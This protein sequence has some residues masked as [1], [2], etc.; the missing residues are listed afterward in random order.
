MITITP[1]PAATAS[2]T[3]QTLAIRIVQPVCRPYSLTSLVQPVGEVKF[4]VGPVKVIDGIAVAT[5]YAQG[6]ITYQPGNRCAAQTRVFNESFPLAL[7][8]T[9]NNE[10]S[11]VKGDDVVGAAAN[12]KCCR[13]YGFSL[14]TTAIVSIS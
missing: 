10:I 7:T 2:A 8:A 13:A 3:T 1:V 12:I 14:T 5:A 6:T 9:G 4:S 11:I